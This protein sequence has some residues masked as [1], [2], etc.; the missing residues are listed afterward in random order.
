MRICNFL[1]CVYISLQQMNKWQMKIPF[2]WNIFGAFYCNI[3][4]PATE[5]LPCNELKKAA[6]ILLAGSLKHN[7]S[8]YVL[9]VLMVQT[10]LKKLGRSK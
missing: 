5:S 6:T 7:C 3:Q 2:S 1:P 4:H 10:V 9:T 8:G